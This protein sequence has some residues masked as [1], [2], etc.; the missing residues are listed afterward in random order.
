MRLIFACFTFD[1]IV[2]NCVSTM[3][4]LFKINKYYIIAYIE[5]IPISTYVEKVML[6]EYKG[7]GCDGYP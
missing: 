7:Q 6:N 2:D 4:I 3:I 5:F 1:F